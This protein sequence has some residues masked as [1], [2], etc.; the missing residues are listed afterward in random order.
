MKKMASIQREDLVRVIRDMRVWNLDYYI[1]RE[2]AKELL[3]EGKLFWE[4]NNHSYMSTDGS[5]VQ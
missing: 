1:S 5:K 4:L 3:K 2:R